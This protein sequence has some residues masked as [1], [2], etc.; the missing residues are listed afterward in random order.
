M[1]VQVF[2]NAQDNFQTEQL[3]R[4]ACTDL[5]SL[6][7]ICV[8]PVYGHEARGLPQNSY[9]LGTPPRYSPYMCFAA[10]D[11]CN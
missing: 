8:N 2:T 6:S 7:G 1:L 3:M 4:D 10:S 9:S 11:M 5:G